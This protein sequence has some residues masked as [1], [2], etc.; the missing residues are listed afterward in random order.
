MM[1]ATPRSRSISTYS[2]SVTPPGV[3]VHSTGVYPSWA[4]TVSMTWANAGKMGFSSSGTTSP[5][6]PARRASSRDG[7]S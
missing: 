4:S 1:P 2:S 7:R 5:T 6:S 3:W